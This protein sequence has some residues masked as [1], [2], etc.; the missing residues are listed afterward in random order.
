MTEL[1]GLG[2]STPADGGKPS[3]LVRLPKISLPDDAAFGRYAYWIGDEG[4]KARVNLSDARSVSPSAADR[5]IALRS[6]VVAALGGLPGLDKLTTPSQL[7]RIEKHQQLTLL[8]GFN[9]DSLPSPERNFFHDISFVSAGVIAD[10]F[11][12]GLR[13]DLSR[14]FELPDD[15]FANTE[16]GEGRNTTGGTTPDGSAATHT[17]NGFGGRTRAKGS[18]DPLMMAIVTGPTNSGNGGSNSSAVAAP[19]FS[20]ALPSGGQLRGPSWWVLRDYHRLYQQLGWS[21]GATG[22]RGTGIPELRARTFWPNAAV[23]RPSG[24]PEDSGVS[25]NSIRNR[26]YGYPDI[27][28]GNQP[29]TIDPNASDFLDGN[30]GRLVTRPLHVAATP[31]VQRVSLAFSFSKSFERVRAPKLNITPI[32]VIHNPYNVRMRWQPTSAGSANTDAYPAAISL[33]DIEDWK[34]VLRQGDSSYTKPLTTLLRAKGRSADKDDTFRIYLRGDISNPNIV[35]EPGELRVFSCQP[36]ATSMPSISEW[37]QSS[38]ATNQ[39]TS[40]R[41][42]EI[43]EIVYS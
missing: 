16:F 32:V 5:L 14:A 15:A 37:S 24:P 27:Y 11:H 4:I 13:R 26:A 22:A 28:D 42:L 35:L 12:G 39:F 18:D 2:S 33:S 31:Y 38:A 9:A 17:E 8:P 21:G 40:G 29:S 6:P 1:V 36:V 25:N 34:L 41:A 30:R 43:E 20:R 10:S 23:A 19:I 3:G 7:D